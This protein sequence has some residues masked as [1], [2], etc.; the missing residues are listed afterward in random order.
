MT[1]KYI[2]MHAQA[3]IKDQE[4]FCLNYKC[5]FMCLESREEA[6]EMMKS[7]VYDYDKCEATSTPSESDSDAAESQ[8]VAGENMGTCCFWTHF[9]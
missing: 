6:E 8:H 1:T 2:K 9:S 5:I 4:Y 3:S 7:A